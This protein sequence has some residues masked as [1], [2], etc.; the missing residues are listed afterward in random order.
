M[1]YKPDTNQVFKTLNDVRHGML[2]VLFPEVIEDEMLEYNGVFP[3]TTEPPHVLEN[4]IARERTIELVDGKWAMS[5]E[6]EAMTEEEIR[7]LKPAV[8]ASVS[9]RQARQAL[10]IRGLLSQVPA[11]LETI[12]DDMQRELA[13]IEWEDSLDFDRNRPLVIQIGLA[14]GLDEE[15]LDE[16]F[17]FAATL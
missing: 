7:N 5:Y 12:T 13:K 3:V 15:G 17:I 4:F 6:V 9:R 14:L 1:Y 10:H 2:H 8:P 11:L 16:L